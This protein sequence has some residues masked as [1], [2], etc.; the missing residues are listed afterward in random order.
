MLTFSALYSGLVYSHPGGPAL[1][2]RDTHCRV[3]LSRKTGPVSSQNAHFE[4]L[5][6]SWTYCRAPY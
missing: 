3:W 2:F 6:H 4:I 5:S 1:C